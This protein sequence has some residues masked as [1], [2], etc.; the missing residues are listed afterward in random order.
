MASLI[1]S[2]GQGESPEIGKVSTY[3]TATSVPD[4][5]VCRLSFYLKCCQMGCGIESNI[6]TEIL[7][8]SNAQCLPREIQYYILKLSLE[9]NPERL[10]NCAYFVD[11]QNR[12]LPPNVSNT[13]YEIETASRFFNVQRQGSQARKVMICTT[14][15]LNQIYFQ[16]ALSMQASLRNA[17]PSAEFGDLTFHCSHCRGLDSADC[18]CESGCPPLYGSCC[19]VIHHGI[20]CNGCMHGFIQG[21]RYR[22]RECVDCDLCEYCYQESYEEHDQLHAFERIARGGASP[23]PLSARAAECLLKLEDNQLHGGEDIPVAIA[24]PIETATAWLIRG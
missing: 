1:S 15:W 19:Q 16:S 3:G 9:L 18:T 10:L 12:L 24:V 13:F 22:C 8:Y 6:P 4:Y 5:D 11:D 20:V 7:D 21:P 2:I 17:L 23:H 14:N